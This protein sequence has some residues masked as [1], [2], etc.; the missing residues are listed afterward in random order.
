MSY[1]FAVRQLARLVEENWEE[2]LAALLDIKAILIRRSAMLLNV[3]TESD[4]WHAF[5]PLLTAFIDDLPEAD[6]KR[7]PAVWTVEH[8]PPFEGMVIPAQVNYV[9][10][11]CN[12]YAAGYRFNGS[13]L[14]VTRYLRNSWLWERVRVQGGAYGAF[15]LFDRLSGALTFVSYRDPNLLKTLETFDQ[16]IDFLKNLELSEDELAKAIIGTIGDIDAYLLPDAKGY[17][18]LLRYLS[19]DSDQARQRMRDEVLATTPADFKAFAEMLEDFKENGLVKVLGSQ[20]SIE[21]SLVRRPEWL[22]VLKV[23]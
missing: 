8:N 11:G 7:Q 2:V 18:S 5:R 21:E 23:L 10:K 16:T 1:L 22:K 14:V 6:G 20:S 4:G 9:G 17:T 13:Y 12:L 3:T 19:G 15:C